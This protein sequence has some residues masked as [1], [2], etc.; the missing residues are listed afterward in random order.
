MKV[1]IE[2]YVREWEHGLAEPED[3]VEG[4]TLEMIREVVGDLLRYLELKEFDMEH[5]FESR[6]GVDE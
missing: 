2:K 1:A 4:L 3:L 6:D 5:P